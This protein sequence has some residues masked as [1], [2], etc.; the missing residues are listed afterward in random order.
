M[1]NIG[2]ILLA[3]GRG[4][5]FG[6]DKLTALLKGK[7]MY[8]WTLEKLEGLNTAVPPVVVTGAAEIISAAEDRGMIT[9]LNRKPEL[10]ISRSI[11]LGIRRLE[12]QCPKIDGILFMVC[13]QP[14]LKKRTLIRLLSEFSGGILAVSDGKRAGNPVIFSDMYIEELNRLTGDVGGRRV[15][16]RHMADVQFLEVDDSRELQDIDT[17]EQLE[18]SE[19]QEEN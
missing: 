3:A 13:D 9:V 15:L 10:G 18:M 7:P 17:R 2:I 4:E 1:M 16:R 5:R 6:G 19:R 11:R 12:Q 14:W 8:L